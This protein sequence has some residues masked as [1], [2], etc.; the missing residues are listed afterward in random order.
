LKLIANG[1]T[2]DEIAANLV[3]SAGTVKTHVNH[4]FFKLDFR[5]RTDAVIFAF[6]RGLAGR[7]GA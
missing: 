3:L 4:I 6:D 5:N 7:A 2:N 1:M